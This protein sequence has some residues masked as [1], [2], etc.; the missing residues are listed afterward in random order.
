M[1]VGSGG[2]LSHAPR[3]AESAYMMLDA[4]QPE[5]VTMLAKDSIFMMP[6]LGVL[7]L[8]HPEAAAQ[9]FDRDCLIKFG[10]AI[11]P[12]GIARPG[13][14]V[15]TIEIDGEKKNYT[16]G[17]LSVIPLGLGETKEVTLNPHKGFDV[18]AGKGKSR[19]ITVE[20]GTVG[21]IVDTRG[22]PLN[23]PTDMKQRIAKLQEWHNSL[24][25][26]IGEGQ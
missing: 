21:L 26:E 20:G 24:G 8:V 25:L 18:G 14:T 3:N 16:F 2:V 10:H 1:I 9:V 13:D 17:S 19:T 22:R 4:Y 11:A 23:L 7:S 12:V 15:L 5:G 6:Q